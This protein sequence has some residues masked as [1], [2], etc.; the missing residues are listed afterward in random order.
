M[1][2]TNEKQILEDKISELENNWKRALA[3]YQNLEKRVAQEKSDIIKYS[4]RVLILK[5]LFIVDSLEMMATHI[6]DEGLKMIL[7]EFEQILKD[8]GVE[9]IEALGLKFDQNTMDA[10]ELIEVKNK[11]QVNKAIEVSQKGY[12]FKDKILRP[13]KVKVGHKKEA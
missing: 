10:V 2:D 13:A 11:K 5:L 6:D 9:E 12:K 7:K 4:N 1:C 8:E 3:D